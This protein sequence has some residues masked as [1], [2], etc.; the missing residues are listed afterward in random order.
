MM[1]KRLPIGFRS[2]ALTQDLGLTNFRRSFIAPLSSPLSAIRL[3]RTTPLKLTSH[4]MNFSILAWP[5]RTVFHFRGTSDLIGFF[6]Q[7]TKIQ[8]S[9]IRHVRVKGFPLSLF[10]SESARFFTTYDFVEALH[11]FPGLQLDTLT[12]EDPF[13]DEGEV[14]GFGDPGAYYNVSALIGSDGWKELRYLSRTTEFLEWGDY[15]TDYGE[16]KRDLQPGGWTKQLEA[17]DGKDSGAGVWLRRA[18][19]EGVKG[20]AEDDS[21]SESWN[22]EHDGVAAT[23]EGDK[24]TR[25]KE[26]QARGAT[27]KSFPHML[28]ATKAEHSLEKEVMV[29]ARRGTGA[30]YVQDGTGLSSGLKKILGELSWA[31]IE[32]KELWVDTETDPCKP[33][34]AIAARRALHRPRPEPKDSNKILQTVVIEQQSSE[35][36]SKNGTPLETQRKPLKRKRNPNTIATKNEANEPQPLLKKRVSKAVV[37]ETSNKTASTSKV[38]PTVTE[39][40]T[41]SSGE[42]SVAKNV[43]S[44]S[45]SLDSD[46]D[47]DLEGGSDL[48]DPVAPK[49]KHSIRT[50][51]ASFLLSKSNIVH[52]SF[53]ECTIKLTDGD[54]LTPVGH[55][56][57]WV[58]KGNVSILGAILHASPKL[59]RVYAPS[60]HSL[61][62]IRCLRNPFGPAQQPAEVT[63]TSCNSRIR[64]LRRVSRKFRRI[65]NHTNLA[66]GIAP[67]PGNF[68]GTSFNL[69]KDSSEDTLHRPLAPLDICAEWQ[70]MILRLT[71]PSVGPSKVIMICG[72]KGAGKSTLSRLLA[73]EFITKSLAASGVCLLDLDLGQP[74]YSPP[75]DLSLVHLKSYNFGPPYTHPTIA[76]DSGDILIRAHH[77][78]GITPR[79]D[80]YHYI[81]CTLDLYNTYR[82]LIQNQPPCPLVINSCGW[83]L[84]S[85]LDLLEEA[86][87]S[88]A[89][90]DVVYMSKSGPDEVVDTL[91]KAAHHAGASF[92]TLPSQPST[93]APKTAVDLRTMQTLSYFHLD[94]PERGTLRWNAASIHTIE[95]TNLYYAGPHQNILGVMILGD[96]MTTTYLAD[97]INGSVLG[98]VTIE[99]DSAIP[100]DAL[101]EYE[102]AI[103]ETA[104]PPQ[105]PAESR[106]WVERH[107]AAL[108]AMCPVANALHRK[109]EHPAP[110]LAT[111]PTDPHAPATP[112]QP[113]P[114]IRRS[115][116]G[117]PHLFSGRGSNI[118]LAPSK[119]RCIG[120]AL[121]RGIDTRVGALE[122]ITPVAAATFAAARAHG[123]KI[124]LVRGRLDMPTWA[125]EEEC[126]EA[127][128]AQEERARWRRH[129]AAGEVQ[130]SEGYSGGSEDEPEFDVAEWASRQKWVSVA[131][132]EDR[133]RV[134]KGRRR[135]GRGEGGIGDGDGDGG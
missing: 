6:S 35:S 49:P 118:P 34:S 31:E 12:V 115:K 103:S 36:S 50:Q 123:R 15:T 38:L 131:S 102:N 121:V 14:D 33:L 83:V 132:K 135:T 85:G 20:A 17:R 57:L 120:Q 122:V 4:T 117:I 96:E 73:N 94:E 42:S 128:T 23:S 40:V 106:S 56:D 25:E 90:T 16:Y 55:Y 43:G 116:E 119:T 37:D 7:L 100:A 72:P 124:V 53:Q 109:T 79:D 5:A 92:H 88:I 68:F 10:A 80:P 95:P 97:L 21:A 61:P 18:S 129:R 11:M 41:L 126:N 98:I 99:D 45:S 3:H 82:R 24:S 74:E 51:L 105:D 39:V 60:S 48:N 125:Y 112:R 78:G 28:M 70:D 111:L 59:Y 8:L 67:T 91:S 22:Q 62:S 86:V 32:E 9:Q 71:D 27:Y 1:F 75:G 76:E 58:R 30:R 77:V 108:R 87:R 114:S 52:S 110:A 93:S 113:K 89:P 66:N 29:V 63:F 104:P 130:D 13:H 127:L 107:T 47:Y 2:Q 133:H 46:S 26:E 134:G 54:T 44:Q 69:L 65:W 101:A 81:Q 19:E 84:G 64:L